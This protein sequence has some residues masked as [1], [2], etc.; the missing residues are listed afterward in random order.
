MIIFEY[1]QV[2]KN[3]ESISYFDSGKNE[4][5]KLILKYKKFHSYNYEQ[6]LAF[7]DIPENTT[8]VFSTSLDEEDE[9]ENTKKQ[10]FSVI[11]NFND[12]IT[13]VM[14]S[15]LADYQEQML[16]RFNR[17]SGLSA[18]ELLSSKGEIFQSTLKEYVDIDIINALSSSAYERRESYGSF[19]FINNLET[20]NFKVRFAK[21]IDF[22]QNNLRLIR[23]FLQMSANKLSLL[24]YEKKIVGLGTTEEEN[25]KRI[26]FNGHQKWTLYINGKD[27]LRFSRGEFFLDY[28]YGQVISDLPKGFLAKK[29]EK[30]FN[31]I[32]KILTRQKHGGLLIISDEAQKEVGR[33]SGMARGYAIETIDFSLSEN[34]GL[35]SHLAAIDGAMFFDRQLKCYGIGI[36][37]DGVAKRPG[38]GARGSRYNSSFCYLDNKTEAPYAAI[39]FS[40]DETV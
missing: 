25:V 36:I 9:E 40:E 39:V 20:V 34:M 8:T 10:T 15:F 13:V 4:I 11:F 2:D 38:S 1:N 37:L 32:I 22:N 33:L 26:Q 14:E 23:K 5:T 16:V 35:I 31:E 7:W 21:Q 6:I 3:T 17:R 29:L 27:A 24:V 18:G 28:G 30:R 19:I 12:D